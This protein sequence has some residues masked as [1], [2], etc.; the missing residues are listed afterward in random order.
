MR[1]TT[2]GSIPRFDHS[3]L[4]EALVPLREEWAALRFDSAGLVVNPVTGTSV[5]TLR[6]VEGRHRSPG[7]RYE[8]VTRTPAIHSDPQRPDDIGTPT[9]EVVETVSQLTLRSDDARALAVTLADRTGLWTIDVDVVHG[10]I[11]RVDLTA[12]ADATA[13]LIEGGAPRWLARRVGG[14]ATGNATIDLATFEH[15]TT[16]TFFDGEGRLRLVH[17][18]GSATVTPTPAAWDVVASADLGGK[19]LG[20]LAL[21]LFG[22]RIQRSFD[23]SAAAYWRGL[24]ETVG[25]TQTLLSQLRTVVDGEGGVAPLL[26]LALWDPAQLEP[27]EAKYGLE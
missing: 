11:P 15:R 6:L 3:L 22:T 14:D 17:A 16:S 5:D 13:M 7:A 12:Q 1:L 18:T 24:P 4:V 8:I 10:R 2:S 27:L 25:P 19:G 20:R 26:H 21:R 9:G 23:T